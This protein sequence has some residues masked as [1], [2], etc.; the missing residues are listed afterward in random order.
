VSSKEPITLLDRFAVGI[1]S[2]LSALLSFGI[3]AI[4]FVF[5]TEGTYIDVIFKIALSIVVLFFI[6]GFTT[7]DNYF[8]SILNPIWELIGK[9]IKWV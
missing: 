1:L 6:L 2:A 3:L 4:L 9:L 5:V 8:I 7:L